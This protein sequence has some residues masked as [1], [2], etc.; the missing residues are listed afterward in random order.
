M[1]EINAH[2][3]AIFHFKDD[4]TLQTAAEKYEYFG[5]GLLIIEDGIVKAVGPADALMGQLPKDVSPVPHGAGLIMPGF[6]DAH[7]H[8]PQP[9]A[10]AG[11]GEELLEWLHGYI[12]PEEA[13]FA[14]PAYAEVGNAFFLDELLRNGTTTAAMYSSSHMLATDNLFEQ[15]YAR[16]MRVIA[17]KTLMDQ[18][19]PEGT[20]DNAQSAYDDSKTLIEKWHGKGRLQYGVTPRFLPACSPEEMRAAVK[21][22]QEFPD[23]YVQTHL[24]ENIHEVDLVRRLYPESL[25]YLDAYDQ[26]GILGEKTLF[27]HCIHLSDREFERMAETG[28]V[29]CWC[30][31]SNSFLGSG[32]FDLV[33]AKRYG[34]NIALATDLCASTTFSML[35]VLCEGYKVTAL[36]AETKLSPFQGFYLVTLGT[37]KALSLDT[38]IGNFS[39]GK[40]ADFIVLDLSATPLLR[41]RMARAKSLQDTLF[42]LMMLG[43]DRVVDKTYLAGRLAMSKS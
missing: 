1:S 9:G 21:I 35:E 15:A 32:I 33:R 5:D 12:F 41:Y 3:G 2:R 24:S 28:S 23:V 22:K 18:D 4:A 19:A 14:D 26:Y 38:A 37:A 8:A 16:N 39:P 6:L 34:V 7:C 43:N 30:P 36:R 20:L 29:A 13:H 10:I 25:D 11:Y 31:D 17:G 27:G 42:V 40:E